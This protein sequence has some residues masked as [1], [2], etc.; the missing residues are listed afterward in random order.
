MGLGGE[1]RPGLLGVFEEDLEGLGL[2]QDALSQA[3]IAK[4]PKALVS[5]LDVA[6][7]G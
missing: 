3:P 6:R 2:R 7:Q 4:L 1:E 5:D